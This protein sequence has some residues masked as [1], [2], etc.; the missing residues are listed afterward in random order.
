METVA[1]VTLGIWIDRMLKIIEINGDVYDMNYEFILRMNLLDTQRS[2]NGF[3]C[4][5]I[6]MGSISV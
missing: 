5:L 6:I 4:L 3:L 2:L 1:R